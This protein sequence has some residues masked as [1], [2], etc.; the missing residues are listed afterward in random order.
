MRAKELEYLIFNPTHT[1]KILHYFLSG[2]QSIDKNGIKLEL[3]NLVLPFIY[4]DNL[5]VKLSNLNKKSKL[6]KLL[7]IDEYQVFFSLINEK[8]KNYKEN[9][10]DAILYLSNHADL[11]IEDFIRITEEL[12]YIDETDNNF[13]QIYKASYNMGLILA[14]E[15]YIDVFLK[16]RITEL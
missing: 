6:N 7:I 15:R 1:S 5:R 8:I 12:S 11:K 14:K 13:K 10:K 2:A 4:N 16:L 3:V 9:T